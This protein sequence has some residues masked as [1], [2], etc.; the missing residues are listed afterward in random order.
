M[1]LLNSGL[2]DYCR[3]FVLVVDILST[4]SLNSGNCCSC[5]LR[6]F[7]DFVKKM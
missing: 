3:L 1:V 2:S 4:V 6:F 7:R 5:E